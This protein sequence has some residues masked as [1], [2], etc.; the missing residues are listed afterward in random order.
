MSSGS[1][2]PI[3]TGCSA[4][5]SS[6][7]RSRARRG[8]PSTASAPEPAASRRRWRSRW[9][10]SP[11]RRRGPGALPPRGPPALGDPPPQ[12]GRGLRLRRPAG[13]LPV[14]HHGAAERREPGRAPP[15]GAAGTSSTTLALQAAAGLAHIHRQGVVHMDLK[16]ANLGLAG[17]RGG[18]AR[19][20]RS[21]TSA[22]PRSGAAPLDRRIRGTLA[23]TAPEVLLQDELRPPRRPLLAGHDAVRA[24]HGRPPVG[25]RG[26]GGDPLPS[27]RRAARSARRC[28]PTC[29]RPWRA[30][31]CACCGATPASAT[32]RRAG[33]WPTWRQALGRPIDAAGLVLLRRQGPRQPARRPRRGARPAAL[34]ARG[35]G[36][37][38]GR[39]GG[40][41]G[42]GGGGQEPAPAR[43][44]AVRRGRGGADRPRPRDAPRRRSPSGRSLEALR[45][46]GARGAEPGARRSRWASSAGARATVSTARSPSIWP[47]MPRPARRSCCCST[48]STWR[49]PR[50]RSC[51]A[52]LGEELR[53]VRASWSWRAGVRPR[54]PARRRGSRRSRCRRLALA[55]LDR[56][57][58]GASGRRLPGHRRACRPASTPG[59]TSETRGVPGQVQQLLRH[60]VDDRVLLYRDGEWKP[61]LPA[62]ARWASSPGGREAQD[63][64]RLQALPGRR[65]RGAGRRGG[66]RRRLLA[67]PCWRRSSE[68][69]PQDLYERLSVAGRAGASRAAAGGRRRRLPPAAAAASSQ[70]LYAQLDGER[71]VALHRRLAALLEERL[72]RGR[73]RAGPRRSPS[74]SGAAATGRGA[75]PYLLRAAAEATAVYGY[76]QAAAFYRPGRRGR[77]RDRPATGGG[78]R[79]RRAGRGARR[80]RASIPRALRVYQDLLKRPDLRQDAPGRAALCVARAAAAPGAAPHPPGRA[81]GGPGEPRR[82]AAAP[83]RVS[84][85][86]R[87][88]DR[89]APRQGA[90][91]A[92]PRATGTPPSRPP[93]RRWPGP[94]ARG[95]SAS[96]PTCSTRSAR[97]YS[98]RGDW[99]RAGRLIRRGLWVAERAGRRGA[100]PDAAQQPGQR[101]LE[102]RPLRGGARPLQP[103]PRAVRADPRPLGPAL[104][105]QQPRHPGVQPRQLDGGARAADAQRRA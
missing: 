61:S 52:Y 49:A 91:P 73:A 17:G 8:P 87:A 11:E 104:R 29:R 31:S 74:T 100:L 81:R 44:P 98:D 101:P 54:A 69:D 78:A 19:S 9:R 60:L 24:G 97:S 76:A 15:R 79:P 5:S 102:D 80:R 32:P 48:T 23:Y 50:A 82:G 41:R 94:A 83:R 75:C 30:S 55:P 3:S 6:R 33:C 89:P 34:R 93:A 4:T 35:G 56:G 26:P 67:G 12:R 96:A 70:A 62:L 68:E 86:A 37:G 105:P 90:G 20:S 64:Q 2:S 42:R 27:G 103:Q 99:R 53:G 38:P 40:D 71:R 18:R 63:W 65:A 84:R 85:R 95:S 46:V 28:G 21:S 51:C 16:P 14:P 43:V 72:L 36:G 45:S 77:R 10:S 39:R 57:G 47:P 92:R 7:A 88:G 13:G 66:D 58:D 1:I 22:W 59:S 25:R